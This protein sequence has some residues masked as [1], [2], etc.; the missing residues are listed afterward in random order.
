[1]NQNR[2]GAKQLLQLLQVIPFIALASVA[3]SI[4]AP[5]LV[6]TIYAWF[7][8]SPSDISQFAQAVAQPVAFVSVIALALFISRKYYRPEASLTQA[9]IIGLGILCG[10]FFAA[11]WIGE[12]DKWAVMTIIA[13]PLVTVG[14]WKLAT[15]SVTPTQ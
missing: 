12:M 14:Y 13:A 6:I 4:L 8:E 9:F 10:L 5:T 15:Q 7:S 11:M 1:M 2:K 3:V